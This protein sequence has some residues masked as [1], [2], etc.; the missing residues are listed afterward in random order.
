MD[1]YDY[2]MKM[3]LDGKAFYEKLAAECDSEG[4]CHIFNEL[5]QDEQKHFDIF[6]KLKEKESVESMIDS[7]ALEGA[8]NLFAEMQADQTT[9]KLL[10]TNLDGYRYAMKAEQESVDL[11]LEAAGKESDS[12]VK[13]L[14]LRIAAE[15]QKHLNILEN[16][17]EFVKTPDH[18]LVW[19]EWSNLNEL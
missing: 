2:A 11:Y 13:E 3:E 15:E 5:A 6:H 19:G 9:R 17:Y 8:K 18:T 12:T 14:L 7:T 16:V 1:V 10:K 4:L